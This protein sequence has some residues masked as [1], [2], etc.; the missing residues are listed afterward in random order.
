MKIKNVPPPPH[1]DQSQKTSDYS[2]EF[3]FVNNMQLGPGW[4]RMCYDVDGVEGSMT[5][6]WSDHMVYLSGIYN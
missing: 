1:L 6:G 3:D 2:G 5:A 4:Y